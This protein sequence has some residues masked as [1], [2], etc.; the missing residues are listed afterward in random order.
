MDYE[1]VGPEHRDVKDS[2][3]PD[4]RVRYM[5][6]GGHFFIAFCLFGCL[7]AFAIFWLALS[8]F[9]FSVCLCCSLSKID[10]TTDLLARFL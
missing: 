5:H 10:I 3:L 6:I 7:Q 8:F 1:T 9:F 4:M 2:L